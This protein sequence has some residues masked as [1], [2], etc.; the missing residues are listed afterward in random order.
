MTPNLEGLCSIQL[1]Y[2]AEI[3]SKAGRRPGR[4]EG[5]VEMAAKIKKNGQGAKPFCGSG[6]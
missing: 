5:A 1:S 2:R 4:P 6:F 3:H